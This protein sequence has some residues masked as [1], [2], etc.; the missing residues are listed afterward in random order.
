MR[1]NGRAY[2]DQ[3]YRWDI[4]VGKYRRLVELFGE[5]A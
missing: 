3:N 2:V 1:A 5:P 4:I